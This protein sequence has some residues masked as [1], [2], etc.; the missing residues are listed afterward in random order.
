MQHKEFLTMALIVTAMA[1]L[2]IN[3]C[4]IFFSLLEKRR[5]RAFGPSIKIHMATTM[6]LILALIVLLSSA[7]I[8]Q[9]GAMRWAL[10]LATLS[11]VTMIPCAGILA[12]R[13][14]LLGVGLQRRCMRNA[15]QLPN[16]Q[17]KPAKEGDP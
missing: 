1:V 3:S 11:V 2:L 14:G 9:Q 10:L 12:A 7:F 17:S 8:T 5:E 15:D 13:L 4:H 6:L 16:E